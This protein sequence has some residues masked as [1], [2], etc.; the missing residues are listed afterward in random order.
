MSRNPN[1]SSPKTSSAALDNSSRDGTPAHWLVGLNH[2]GV[3]PGTEQRETTRKQEV[4]SEA[5]QEKAE[6]G[7][8]ACDIA[9]TTTRP[10]S[11]GRRL[12]EKAPADEKR[13]AGAPKGSTESKGSARTREGKGNGGV[14]IA[15]KLQDGKAVVTGVKGGS[16]C[17][18]SSD[19]TFSLSFMLTCL[20]AVRSCKDMMAADYIPLLYCGFYGC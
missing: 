8:A 16:R 18:P 11:E 17:A 3:P 19:S 4:V 9:D 13:V 1:P 20:L 15:I 10:Q 5:L 14:G 7:I 2:T 6:P 12:G